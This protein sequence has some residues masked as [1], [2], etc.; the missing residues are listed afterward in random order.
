MDE[1]LLHCIIFIQ[2][3]DQEGKASMEALKRLGQAGKVIVVDF[4]VRYARHRIGWGVGAGEDDD[5][6]VT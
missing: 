4:L 5:V 1:I 3:S 6:V 2:M